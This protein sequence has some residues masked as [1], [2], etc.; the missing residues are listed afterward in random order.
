MGRRC[1]V[2][3]LMSHPAARA[4]PVGQ[5]RPPFGTQGSSQL[6]FNGVPATVST[7]TAT[8]ITA[9]VPAGGTSGFLTVVVAGVA[10]DGVVFTVV[11]SA[12]PNAVVWDTFT[13]VSGTPLAAHVP[14]VAPSGAVWTSWAGTTAQIAD[15]RAAASVPAAA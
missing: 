15:H 10:S 8:S 5:G 1:Q 7:W 9:S 13:D 6:R 14:D 3:F 12:P 11:E 4:G 2:T